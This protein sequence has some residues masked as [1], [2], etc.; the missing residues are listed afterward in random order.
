MEGSER[1]RAFYG[2]VEF[3]RSIL[4]TVNGGRLS[5]MPLNG[6]SPSVRGP[7]VRNIRS[8]F[9]S[10]ALETVLERCWVELGRMSD[11]SRNVF[12]VNPERP[13]VRVQLVLELQRIIGGSE[14]QQ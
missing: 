5:G 1:F 13:D 7:W 12:E 9:D 4:K 3:E 10:K 14:S 8:E 6:L 11:Q 2:R